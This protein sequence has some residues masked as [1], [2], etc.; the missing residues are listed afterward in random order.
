MPHMFKMIWI[1]LF[2]VF[3]SYTIWVYAYC[4]TKIVKAD[5]MVKAG[6]STWQEKNCQ[7]CHQLYGLGGYMGPDL[8][9]TAGTKGAK[10]LKTFIKYGTGRMPDY[11]LSDTEIE[12]L[13]AFLFWVDKT[14]Q[15]SVPQSAVHW[16]GSYVIDKKQ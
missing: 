12:G 9:N 11:H 7:S 6:W 1:T 16:S 14:G 5:N 13:V 10:Y 3:L 15:S 2:L 4:D 8:T